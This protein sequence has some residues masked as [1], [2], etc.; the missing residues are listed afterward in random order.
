M[1]VIAHRLSTIAQSDKILVL[2]EGK[3]IEE[4]THHDLLSENSVYKSMWDKQQLSIGN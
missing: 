4:G 1:I 3:V 2:K